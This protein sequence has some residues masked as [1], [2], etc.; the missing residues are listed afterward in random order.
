MASLVGV[1]NVAHSPT[2][3]RPAEEWNQVRASRTLRADVAMDDLDTNRKKK[4]RVQAAFATLRDRPA[5]ARPGVLGIFGAD[6]GE[7]VAL[8]TCPSWPV[9]G[10]GASA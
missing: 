2:C 6:Q 5:A 9:L 10:R 1:F 8:A 4:A 3:Y 7:C